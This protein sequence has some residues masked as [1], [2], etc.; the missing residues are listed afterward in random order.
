MRKVPVWAL[1]P[2]MKTGRPLYDN[3]GMLLLN[4]KVSIKS[5]YIHNLKMLGINAIYIEDDIIP[6]VSIEDVIVDETRTKA[7]T[8]VRDILEN[9]EKQPEKDLPRV[10]F[11]K[12]SVTGI[13]ENIV[14][15]LLQNQNLMIN[16][17]DIR[18]SDG[19][20]FAHCV[21]VAVLAVTA[22]ISLKYSRSELKDIAMG[23]L[24][25]D[26]G[27]VKVPLEILNKNGRLTADEFN[28]I[29]NHPRFGYDMI[30][31]QDFIKSTS[32]ITVY[33]H[34]ERI[35]G[36]G[37]P[38]GLSDEQIHPFARI[39]AVTDVYDALV[40]DRPYRK[41]MPPHKAL[42]ILES[43]GDEYDLNMLQNFMQHIA[44]Y[45]IGNIVGLSSGEI[46]VVVHNT[47]G[48]PWRPRVRVFAFKE[49]PEVI[50]PYE[51]DLMDKINV[52]VDRVYEEKEMQEVLPQLEK[53]AAGKT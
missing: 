6:D 42:E 10:L 29:K 11:A 40:A 17:S 20:T 48:Y 32:C 2:G 12:T 53:S 21:N 5:K 45:P 47:V 51:I 25:H 18:T 22:G 19:Y 24:L 4:A 14:D 43:S 44:A 13:V 36:K 52:V 31:T 38:E 27:K 28:Q 37:Y 46:G 8:M 3:K 1:Q 30:R 35:N 33:Q 26:L 16:L 50:D 41:A 9:I 49:G 23:A 15:Q 39:A 34:H 7:Q